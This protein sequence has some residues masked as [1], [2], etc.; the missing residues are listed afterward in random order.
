MRRRIVLGVALTALFP[1]AG[2]AHRLDE[3]L[4]ATRVALE[5]QSI[6]LELELTPGS[7][8]ARSVVNRIDVDHDQRFSGDEAESY[9]RLVLRDVSVWLDG[10]ALDL[11]LQHVEVATPEELLA[12]MGAI[13]MVAT[14]TMVPTLGRHQLKLRNNHEN[15]AVYLMNALVPETDDIIITAQ[16][17]DGR[18]QE[19][20]IDY[21][22]RSPPS[23][24]WWILPLCL[25]VGTFGAR[26]LRERL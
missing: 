2:G 23:Q 26:R 10:T 24:L 14:R 1:A 5:P 6:R 11:R 8:I 25:S 18:Q 13:S 16:S 9:A 21:E 12:G 19:F 15:A 22:V 17:R 7:S 4:H 3:F 20:S